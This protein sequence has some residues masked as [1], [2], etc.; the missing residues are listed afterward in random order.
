MGPIRQY[1]DEA[2]KTKTIYPAKENLFK[3]LE[4]TPMDKVKVVI[5]GQDPYHGPNQAQGLSFSVP[6]NQKIPPSLQNIYKE[7]EREYQQ[8]IYRSGDLQDWAKQGVLLLNA[9]LSVEAGKPNSHAN[10]G[11][12]TFTDDVLRVL[13]QEDR[14]IVFMLWGYNARQAAKFLNNPHHL[15]L[16]STHP[17]PLSA[18]KGFIGCN[19]FKQANSFLESNGLEPIHWIRD[20]FQDQEKEQEA[21]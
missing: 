3:A 12:K 4:L 8:P 21:Q 19:H 15:V 16:Q 18:H 17:S 11:W 14:P 10:I 5:I 7:L 2:Y 20:N 9:A 13:N 1:L 6:A